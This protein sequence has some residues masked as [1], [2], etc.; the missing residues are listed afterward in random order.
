MNVWRILMLSAWA[1]TFICD[2]KNQCLENIDVI[3]MSTKVICA[4]KN[5]CLEND[6][7]ICMSIKIHLRLQKSM[8]GECWCYLHGHQNSFEITKI[9]VWR[10]LMLSARAS[11]FICA[12]E[13]QCLG[14]IDGI[15]ILMLSAW[16]SKFN[17]AVKNQCLENIHVICISMKVHLRLQKNV[18]RILMLSAYAFNFICAYKHQCLDNMDVICGVINIHLS[19]QK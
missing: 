8:F 13:N 17:C 7:V 4:Y 12:Y 6:N 11:K 1:S 15:C 18:W 16:A 19:L 9:N 3:Y 14:N 5:Q 10:M 2:Y